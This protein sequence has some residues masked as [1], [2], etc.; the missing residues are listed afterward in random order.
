MIRPKIAPI[1]IDGIIQTS[2]HF[3]QTPIAQSHNIKDVLKVHLPVY[4]GFLAML[5]AGGGPSVSG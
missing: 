5:I 1:N 4:S 3:T 2:D